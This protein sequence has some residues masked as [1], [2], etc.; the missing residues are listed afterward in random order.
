LFSIFT[1]H[2][3]F[4]DIN[5]SP[6]TLSPSTPFNNL[7]LKSYTKSRTTE[8]V[9]LL[10]PSPSKSDTPK[11][12][13]INNLINMP[14]PVSKRNIFADTLIETPRKKILNKTIQKQ[15]KILHNKITHISKLK[16]NISKFKKQNTLKNL[17]YDHKFPS[18]NSRAIVTMQLRN[19]RRPW[20]IEEKNL[21]LSLFYKSPT[22]YNFLRLQ[23]V[24]LPSPSTVRRWIG[25]SKYLPGFNKLFLSHLKR[26]FEFKTYKDK[27]CSVCF[28]E[29]SIKELLEY[30][31]NFD[32]IEGFEDLGRLGRTSKTANT[33]LVFMARGV[34]TSWKIPIA[35]FLAHS[36]VNRDI[37]KTLIIDVLQVLFDT[38]LI[39]K[40]IICDQGTNNQSALKLLNV[41]EDKPFFYVGEHKLFALFDTPHLLKSIR[42]N[43]IGN[44]FKK[45]DIIISFNDIVQ[46]YNIDK[47]NQKSRALLKITD[48]H[49]RPNS[50][51]K[52]SVKLAAQVLSHTMSSTIRTCISTKELKSE[53]ANNTADFV[54]FIDK[55]FDCLNSRTLYNSN[56][57]NCALTNNSIVK[58]FLSKACDYFKNLVK[59]KNEKVTRPPCFNGFIQTINGVLQFFEE[60]K[61]NN[62][63]FLLTNRLN[64][65]VIE[66][67][68]SI[69]RQRGGYNK[70]PT[71]KTLRTSFRITCVFSLCQSKGTN[72]EED[73]DID[74]IC[75]VYSDNDVIRSEIMNDSLSD[76][77]SVSSLPSISSPEKLKVKAHKTEKN[78]SI[79]LEDCSVT[80]FS[81]Y[82]AY[83]CTEKFNCEMCKKS[84]VTTKNMNSKNQLLILFKN[85]PDTNKDGGL[86]APTEYFNS[87]I[88]RALYIFENIFSIIQHQKKIKVKIIKYL[89]EDQ[90]IS[91][92]INENDNACYEHYIFI[93]EKLIICKI[94]KKAKHFSTTSCQ[95]KIAKLKIL[96]HI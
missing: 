86:K 88:D 23:R 36:A 55:L 21:A 95:A 31:K 18:C 26:K 79:T 14:S 46:T 71:S 69:F 50:F 5:S 6:V 45:G 2:L 60:E 17:M 22:S 87:I 91:T 63:I 20:T 33:A 41:S 1:I 29:I 19:K 40:L 24:N 66:N 64:Q 59:L 77:E 32:F 52:M 3:I 12:K 81:G 82:L 61:N 9:E 96:N 65:D 4:V 54:E 94:F 47:R 43:F 27:I 25:L 76:V 30:S 67:L 44:R 51:Q 72:C 93:L 57:Y 38:G 58:D 42:N 83:K 39:P 49:I 37:L 85:Y 68:F 74:D 62:I 48:A 75:V 89:K 34:Y 7:S 28:D 15:K 13:R 90:L 11:R 16:N 78:E 10:F 8:S 53:T 80:Y 73:N 56:P 70:N 92:W 84:L 35:Y